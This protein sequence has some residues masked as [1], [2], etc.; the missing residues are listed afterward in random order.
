M[1]NK[2][3]T[4][5]AEGTEK[6]SIAKPSGFDLERFKSKRA[7]EIANVE[8]LP[9]ALSVM[10]MA[11]AKDFV[12]LHP[13]EENFWSVELC[14]VD[15]PIKGDNRDAL[16]LIDEDLA[17]RHL[18]SAEIKRFRVALATKPQDVPFLCIIPTQNLDNTY[19]AETIKA[20]ENA[21]TLWT[22]LTSRKREGQETYQTTFARKPEAL[23]E[24]KWPPQTLNEILAT[25]F[26]GRMIGEEDH[27]GLLRL[28]GAKLIP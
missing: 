10:K 25:A 19:N 26:D 13:D 17:M 4:V 6:M 11:A 9:T 24:P 20:C 23:G 15:V 16:H 21:K 7:A 28:L 14:F 2:K 5:V 12:R 18:P 8:T 27:P 1:T 3:L 22:K